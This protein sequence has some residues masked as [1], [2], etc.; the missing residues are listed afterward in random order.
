[1]PGLA[2]LLL[3]AS[4]GGVTVPAVPSCDLEGE[5]P[6]ALCAY[7]ARDFARA[8]QLFRNVI[9]RDQR[10]PATIRSL[11]FLGRI[12]MKDGR[13]DEASSVFIRIHQLDRVFYGEWNCDFLLGL[14]RAALG[15]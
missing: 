1:M 4:F 6:A 15:R 5:Y 7:Q 2:A 13:H 12:L 11:Y 14:S 10:A 8:E 3:L 9:A